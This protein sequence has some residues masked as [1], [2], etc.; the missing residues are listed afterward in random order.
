ML[1]WLQRKWEPVKCNSSLENSLPIRPQDLQGHKNSRDKINNQ[2]ESWHLYSDPQI[3]VLHI[4]FTPHCVSA[5]SRNSGKQNFQLSRASVSDVAGFLTA[6]RK[7]GWFWYHLLPQK[8]QRK[9]LSWHHFC[10]FVIYPDTCYIQSPKASPN[11]KIPR[12]LYL[13]R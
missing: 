10:E 9:W 1:V 13:T 12:F 3:S 2:Q 8:L 7:K 5:P 4:Y 6:T 11:S